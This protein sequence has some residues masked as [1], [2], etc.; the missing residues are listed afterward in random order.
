MLWCCAL[1]GAK[2]TSMVQAPPTGTGAP[3]QSWLATWNWTG[4][5]LPNETLVTVIGV[6]QLIA[7]AVER[8]FGRPAAERD[9]AAPDA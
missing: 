9:V 1:V 8:R 4:L 3:V 6:A 7:T 5:G 2:T